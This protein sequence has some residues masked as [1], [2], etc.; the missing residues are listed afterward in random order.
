L[1][2]TSVVIVE[3]LQ[4]ILNIPGTTVWNKRFKTTPKRSCWKYWF[5]VI[6]G[7][8]GGGC[9]HCYGSLYNFLLARPWTPRQLEPTDRFMACEH[10]YLFIYPPMNTETNIL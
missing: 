10:S 4:H 9:T 7:L 1:N 8:A 6:S 3:I 5:N 2:K